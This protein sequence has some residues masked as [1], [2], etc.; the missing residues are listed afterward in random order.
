MKKF[1]AMTVFAVSS[2][3]AS[4]LAQADT[5]GVNAGIDFWSTSHNGES[6]KKDGSTYNPDFGTNFRPGV[7]IALEHPIPLIPNVMFRYQNLDTSGKANG[8]NITSDQKMYD[9]VLYYQLFDNPAFGFDYGL[10]I[11]H[12]QGTVSGIGASKDYTK[13]MPTL[14]LAANINIPMTGI[15][16]FGNT[17]NVSFDGTRISDSEIGVSYDFLPLVVSTLQLRAGYRVLDM[18]LK[19]VENMNLEQTAQGWFM[20]IGAHF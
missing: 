19:D 11:K 16:V 5:L 13:T 2:L 1:A 6:V 3:L 15:Q 9:G 14:Y 4:S 20:G 10:N 12:F 18:R 17:S 8:T 7:Y